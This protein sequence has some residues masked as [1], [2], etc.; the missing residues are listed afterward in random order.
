MANNT[1][2]Q[3]VEA[4][5]D[6]LARITLDND[7]GTDI[8][9]KIYLYDLQRPGNKLPSIAI[10]ART[11]VIDRTGETR[12]NRALNSKARTM[13]ITIEAAMNGAPADYQKLALDMLE[14]IERAWIVKTELAP[15]ALGL[16]TLDSWQI[17]DS[18]A[19]IEGVVLQIAGTAEY[20]RNP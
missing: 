11:G 4:I 15:A 12:G 3:V 1:P 5:R 7:Y 17:L 18:P 20:I 19:G 8:G 16:I 14:D 13:S 6:Q 2:W 10:G 9:S